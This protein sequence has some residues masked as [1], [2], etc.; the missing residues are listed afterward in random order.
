MVSPAMGRPCATEETTPLTLAES[1]R[2][3]TD[4]GRRDVRGET[5]RICVARVAVIGLPRA[6][7]AVV[8]LVVGLVGVITCSGFGSGVATLGEAMNR[9]HRK[10]VPSEGPKVAALGR[11]EVYTILASASAS[12]SEVPRV[13]NPQSDRYCAHAFTKPSNVAP[14][15]ETKVSPTFNGVLK[16]AD[17]VYILCTDKCDELVIPTELSGRTTLLNGFK[18]DQCAGYADETR[19][20]EKASRAHG[21]AIRDAFGV[22]ENGLVGERGSLGYKGL[23]HPINVLAILEQDTEGDFDVTWDRNDWWAFEAAVKRDDWSL[24]R[25]SHRPY[26]FEN[27]R[28]L[29]EPN[30]QC[31]EQCVCG[32]YGDKLCMQK[33]TGCSMQSSDAYFIH[34]RSVSNIVPDLDLGK[35][36]DYHIFHSL[37]NQMFFIPP[38]AR[39]T[40]YSYAPDDLSV[41]DGKAA[42]RKFMEKCS[43]EVQWV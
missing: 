25:L 13:G 1:G 42:V 2:V 31:P 6:A 14:L 19:H 30:V 21:A 41:E 33:T 29:S 3:G 35:I 7:V 8:V 20:W 11:S 32:K 5:T 4:Q 22:N 24:M 37:P 9:V 38:V 36:I 18:L 15:G 26:D 23:A 43:R 27:G 16:Y 12:A 10:E 40:S 28:G 39:Q 17:A 34:R